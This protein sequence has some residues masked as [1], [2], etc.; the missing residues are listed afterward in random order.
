MMKQLNNKQ[1]KFLEYILENHYGLGWCGTI[2]SIL[3]QGEYNPENGDLQ[4]ILNRFEELKKSDS[5]L[6]RAFRK[7]TKYLK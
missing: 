3:Y 4:I 7:P 1:R 6:E 5:P 2:S